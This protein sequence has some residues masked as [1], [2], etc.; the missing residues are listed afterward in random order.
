MARAC[1][2]TARTAALRPTLH[3]DGAS[4]THL[5]CA[6]LLP[7]P[8]RAPSGHHRH[9]LIAE[10]V[11]APV[12]PVARRSRRAVAAMASQE[13]ATTTAVEEE[14]AQEEEPA[15]GEVKEEQGA[16]AEAEAEASSEDAGGGDAGAAEAEAAGSATKLYFGNLPYNCDSALLAGIVQDHAI[17]EMVEVRLHAV[18]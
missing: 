1:L 16:P 10:H 4:G 3:T 14:T 15:G 11:V 6:S 2:S 9:R 13:E 5:F 18:C 17:P 8:A 12:V 7:R